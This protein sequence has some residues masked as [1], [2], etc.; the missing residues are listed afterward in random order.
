MLSKLNEAFE[1]SLLPFKVDL[2]DWAVISPGFRAAIIAD[3]E[4]L[5]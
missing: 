1:D 5:P 2:I 4:P 3:L